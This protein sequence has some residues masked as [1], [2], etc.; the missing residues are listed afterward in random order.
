M[1]AVSEGTI[2]QQ[3]AKAQVGAHVSAADSHAPRERNGAA[4][5]AKPAKKLIDPR[6]RKFFEACHDGNVEAIRGFVAATPDVVHVIGPRGATAMHIAARYGHPEAIAALL[7]AGADACTRDSNGNTASEK[8]RQFKHERTLAL[9][10][11]AEKG[12]PLPA[13]GLGETIEKRGREAAEEPVVDPVT[14]EASG[15]EGA[16]AAAAPT[17]PEPTAAELANQVVLWQRGMT[18]REL[19]LEEVERPWAASDAFWLCGTAGAAVGHWAR[20][21]RGTHTEEAPLT[22]GRHA[23]CTLQ[24]AD[25]EVSSQHAALWWS[26]GSVMVKDDPGSFNGSFVRLSGEK[27]RS[28]PYPLEPGDVLYIGEHTLTLEAPDASGDGCAL[29]VRKLPTDDEP[30]PPTVR[31]TL[32]RHG[33]T[34]IGRAR[35]NDVSLADQKISASHAEVRWLGA[36]AAAE[37]AGAGSGCSGWVAA[38]L[39]SS[40]G[41]SLRLSAERVASR[42]F[43]MT[44]GHALAIGNGPRSPE[45]ML[46]RC[47][48]VCAARKGRRPTM[49]DAHVICHRL[50][51]PP[52]APPPPQWPAIS[53]FAVYDGHGGGEASE[54]CKSKLHAS[55]SALLAAR[56][57]GEAQAQAVREGTL[58]PDVGATLQRKD[59][60]GM[61]ASMAAGAAK[62]A[63]ANGGGEEGAGGGGGENVVTPSYDGGDDAFPF[64]LAELSGAM[65]RAFVATDEAFLK[66]TSH[67]AGT[68]AVVAMLANGHLVVGNAG[69]SRAYLWR[70]GAA[71]ALSV[72]HKPDRPDETARITRAG[73]PRSRN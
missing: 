36:A 45:M 26:D 48:C 68:T 12:E 4:A 5:D 59:F 53:I 64:G 2:V 63:E 20:V 35:N 19:E 67:T 52:R 1:Q 8:A 28:F 47:V 16:Q 70:D 37:Q 14:P 58:E 27:E 61:F 9:L 11:A 18:E 69:D 23:S 42:A 39:G 50:L 73:E 54:F 41:T 57:T 62:A 17:G 38:D 32:S 25:A 13:V 15:A 66:S 7:A 65:H 33:R 56:L 72:D 22:I 60:A 51:P 49:E 44:A 21:R 3:L 24:L 46:A 40:N 55:L 71:L 29:L 43:R 31:F 10:L 6:C 34:S 30:Q